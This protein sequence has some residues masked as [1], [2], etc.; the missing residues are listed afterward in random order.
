M[1]KRMKS[2]KDLLR[3]HYCEAGPLGLVS[4][5]STELETEISQLRETISE[6]DD[7]EIVGRNDEVSS[8]VKQ[9][10]DAKKKHTTSIL[11]IVGMSGLGKTTLAK[12]VF[13]HPKIKQYF[14][15]TIW[16]CVSEPFLINKILGTI[17]VTLKGTSSGL[18]NKEALLR[19]LK[20]EMRHKSYFLVLDDVWNEN[21][22]LW[23]ELKNCLMKIT[24]KSENSFVVTTRSV[25]VARIM[26]TLPT[27]HLSKLSDDQCWSL[28]QASSNA[29]GL[30]MTSSL[31]LL[32]EELVK[33]IGGIPLVARVLGRALKFQGNYD[34]WVTMLESEIRTPFEEENFVLYVLK[35]S[36]ERLPSCSLKQCFAYCSNFSKD[37]EFEKEQLIQMWIAQGFIHLKKGRS[38][39]TLEDE[40]DMYFKILL[41]R[42]LFQDVNKDDRGRIISCKM[43]DLIHD[44][45]CD[46]SNN[47]SFQLEHSNALQMKHWTSKTKKFARQARTIL[48][49][50][51]IPST[52][53]K[54]ICD[55]I[56][57]FVGLRVLV[58]NSWD[59]YELPDSIHK[60]MHLRYLD[61]S[62][63]R[64]EK[65][66]NSLC[67]LYH[68]Q[69]LR[70][71]GKH[72]QELPNN[73]RE[74][75]SLRHFVFSNGHVDYIQ[76]PP[77]LSQLTQLQTLSI[78]VAGS[79]EGWKIT[80]LGPLKNLKGSL[81]LTHL[82]HVKC[83]EEA[84]S[85]NLDEKENLHGLD[86][87]WSCN[88]HRKVNNHNDLEVLKGFRPHE[89]L[90]HLKI[91]SFR[92]F[93][94]G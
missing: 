14:D 41:S 20:Y 76:M 88:S 54:M 23:D 25:E 63:C 51:L 13:N 62:H 94:Y 87:I 47:K 58:M 36:V 44:I 68:L 24:E 69:T 61:V 57:N 9:V 30:P 56:L 48:C 16:V 31:T 32:R 89:H 55:K 92:A 80:E 75:V 84:E 39:K 11:P 10:I 67:L 64:L 3:K 93:T 65:L 40:G 28:F 6:L 79:K 60:L 53:E 71:E 49:H 1:A 83:K 46:V 15:E 22:S 59:I 81:K 2:I 12:L 4:N 90:Q 73:L 17:L 70:I 72:I 77:H 45:A 43:H 50:E 42:C 21:P 29:I 18:D 26:E 85:A 5:E 78:F 38:N 34:R 7:F 37:F 91:R 74:L 27:H 86:F 52:I 82:E 19:E 35:L 66:P 8:I 33:K